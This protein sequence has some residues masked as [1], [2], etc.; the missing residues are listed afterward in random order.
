MKCEGRSALDCIEEIVLGKLKCQVARP[1]RE[2]KKSLTQVPLESGFFLSLVKGR[3]TWHFSFPDTICT[4]GLPCSCSYCLCVLLSKSD[5]YRDRGWPR[6]VASQKSELVG[7]QCNLA[8]TS[9]QLGPME[10][11]SRWTQTKWS[12]NFTPCFVSRYHS[13]S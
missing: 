11:T 12:L 5:S 8:Q 4:E 10:R 7:S 6:K 2:T 13:F 1:F 3:A 9:N